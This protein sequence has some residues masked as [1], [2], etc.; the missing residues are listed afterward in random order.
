MLLCQALVKLVQVWDSNG[1]RELPSD[2]I[3]EQI[4]IVLLQNLLHILH[5]QSPDGSWRL[6][7]VIMET[8]A[9]A[10]LTLKVL[11]LLP[12][13]DRLR[14]RVLEAVRL[15][16][17]F[18]VLNYDSENQHEH[19][20]VAKVTYALPPIARAY[21][22]AALTAG[23]TY[24][25]YDK[26]KNLMVVPDQNLRKM[27]K[28][29]SALPMFSQDELWALESDVFLGYLYQPMLLRANPGVFP[30]QKMTESKYA[31]YIPFTW[32]AM[33]RRNNY[34]LSNNILWEMMKMSALIYQLDE[35][36]ETL[37]TRNTDLANLTYVR[38]LVRQ[39]CEFGRH[40]ER[41]LDE[42][43]PAPRNPSTGVMEARN[44]EN[45]HGVN[46]VVESCRLDTKSSQDITLVQVQTSLQHFT[47][48][49]LQHPAV[50]QSPDSVRKQLHSEL[51]TGIL[52]HI[53]HEEDNARYA[54]QR[55]L[56]S[57]SESVLP[58]ETVCYASARSS[59]HSW[60]RTTSADNTQ[61]PSTFTFF[62]CLAAPPG[63]SFFRGVRQHYVSSALSRHLANLCRQYNDY[64]SV[65]R[66]R[67]EGNL[68]SIDF[69][70][71]HEI[72][73]RKVD[74]GV[75]NGTGAPTR[76]VDAMKAD[77]ISIAQYERECLDHAIGKLD[78]EL[79]CEQDGRRKM[80]TL[81][82]F[83]DTTDLYGQIY[84]A[85]DISNRLR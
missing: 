54:A 62:S 50:V 32:I 45:G 19:I 12:W 2:L 16:S 53:D 39:L 34:P 52:A 44:A 10:V 31:E 15:G 7:T 65:A 55:R 63:K 56:Q 83:I 77:L 64:G 80:E 74:N 41:K 21:V 24:T 81:S 48:Y 46:G 28:F 42:K 1:L 58:A 5:R 30:W 36:M 8:T 13:H 76:D 79:R 85:R 57:A 37:S 17:A 18:L 69:V 38:Q 47:S 4:P 70:E 78:T 27:A 40:D 60:V 26:G 20:W 49:I 29:F 51:C 72:Y 82:V 9:Y 71:F 61:A 3:R 33:N 35:F 23:T 11:A 14:K 73:D 84:V 25:W 68:N 59:Y 6:G 75:G 43:I 66:D 67:A 22:I